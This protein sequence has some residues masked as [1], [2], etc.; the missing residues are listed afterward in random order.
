MDNCR[1]G[2]AMDIELVCAGSVHAEAKEARL[3]LFKV[4]YSTRAII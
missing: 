1:T 4:Y 3:G 2:L